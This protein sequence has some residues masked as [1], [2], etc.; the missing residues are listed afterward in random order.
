M[1]DYPRLFRPIDSTFEQAYRQF[2]GHALVTLALRVTDY[3]ARDKQSAP[4]VLRTRSHIAAPTAGRLQ[5]R[6][7]VRHDE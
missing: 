5:G 2:H 7:S 6:L 1:T 4:Q 3:L